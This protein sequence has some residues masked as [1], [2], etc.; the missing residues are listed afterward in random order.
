[1][2]L[3]S[4]IESIFARSGTLSRVV[5]HFEWRGQQAEMARAIAAA[6]EKSETLILEAPTGVGKSLAYLIPGALWARAEGKVLF[7]S[8]HTKNLQDQIVRRD[9]PL[10]SRITDRAITLAVC[11]GRGNYLCRR[12]WEIARADLEGTT[13]G[14]AFVRIL[15]GWTQ[16]TESGDVDEGPPVPQKVRHL[17]SR[18]TSDPLFCASTECSADDGCF[19]KLSR[20]RARESHV[21]LVNHALLVRDLLSGGI[22]LPEADAT[23]I[24]EAHNLPGIAAEALAR[25]ISSRGWVSTL[26]TLGGQGEPGVSDRMRRILRAWPSRVE[27]MKLTNRLREMEGELGTLIDS[28]RVFFDALRGIDGYPADGGRVRYRLGAGSGGPFP[29][30]T[31]GLITIAGELIHR[32]ESLF[33]EVA[34][35]VDEAVREGELREI[36]GAIIAA[37]EALASLTYLVEVDDPSAVYWIEDHPS[38]GAVLASRPLDL[39]STLGERLGGGRPLVL[40]SATLAVNGSTSFFATGCGLPP[41]TPSLVLPP[42]F[43]LERQVLA[44]VPRRIHDPGHVDHGIDLAEGI[45]KLA[46]TNSRKILVLF[47][48]HETLRRIEERIRTPLE[49]RG[50]RV[51]AQGRDASRQALTA[52]FLSSERAVLL[53]AASFW[54]GVDLPGEDLEILLMVRLPFPVPTDPFV[55]AYSERLR[56]EGADPFEE[57]MLPEAIVRFRQGF[58]RLIRSREDRGVFVVLDPRILR[59][60]YGARFASAIGIPFHGVETWDEMIAKTR[61]WFGDPG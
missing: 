48:A 58:G 21:V 29:E 57:Y 17:L 13:D 61:E 28:S 5:D 36:E 54:E 56:E 32:H 51:Y 33:E 46:I 47:T 59:R 49:D 22:G 34:S 10:L 45:E 15:E 38:E 7:I 31:Y 37:R 26:I 50:I 23:V 8:T 19:F 42:I 25:R 18:I 24:D 27:R 6:L 4:S 44:L 20:R 52:A 55:E 9:F 60:A 2:T 41:D 39:S 14:E 30:S 35:R 16:I 1:M 43:D 53:G 3:R 40:T 12:R 11:K